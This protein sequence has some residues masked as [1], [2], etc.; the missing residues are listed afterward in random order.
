MRQPKHAAMDAPNNKHHLYLQFSFNYC[1]SVFFCSPG[2]PS[3]RRTLTLH[4]E[5]NVFTL[6]AHSLQ[7]TLGFARFLQ[8]S[9]LNY[10]LEEYNSPLALLAQSF[11]K[12]YPEK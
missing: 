5:A 3:A 2:P 1:R 9:V 8:I 6:Q 12:F 4:S 11:F 7:E 10:E